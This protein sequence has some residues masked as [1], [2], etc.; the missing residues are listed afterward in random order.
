MSGVRVV[1]ALAGL[2]VA[3]LSASAADLT[4]IDRSILKEPAYE[5][6]APKYCLLVLG[7]KAKTRIWLVL[8]GKTLYVDRNGNGDLAEPGE[9][10][11]GKDGVFKIGE[12]LDA[13]TGH[14]H[15]ELV[16]NVDRRI[17]RSDNTSYIQPFEIAGRVRG[18]FAFTAI[19]GFADRAKDAPAV[20]LA[21]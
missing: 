4:R 1:L 18:K 16:V 13:V 14:K 6:T 15:T 21:Q 8:D 7:P 5:T 12:L 11:E 17:E 10:V 20:P 9:Q 2:A 3:S 19:P